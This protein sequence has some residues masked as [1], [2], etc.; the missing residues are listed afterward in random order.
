MTTTSKLSP[1]RQA[2]LKLIMA[3]YGPWYLL[4]L[5]SDEWHLCWCHN[6]YD[7]Q[8]M[9]S[10]LIDD[11]TGGSHCFSTR[12]EALKEVLK[13]LDS[14]IAD[15]G[16]GYIKA[17]QRALESL[18][19]ATNEQDP[20]AVQ[21][22]FAGTSDETDLIEAWL[23][24]DRSQAHEKRMAAK[25]RATF[26]AACTEQERRE[27]AFELVARVFADQVAGEVNDAIESAWVAGEPKSVRNAP[28]LKAGD[29]MPM[30][31][32]AISAG[33]AVFDIPG[34]AKHMPVKTPLSKRH[35]SQG[36]V[37]HWQHPTWLN[38]VVPAVARIIDRLEQEAKVVSPSGR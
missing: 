23:S 18:V 21:N 1:I 16:A 8:A 28:G 17:R 20:A 35:T 6:V 30:P 9:T 11:G 37:S 26:L 4:R 22:A 27:Q 24:S 36:Y 13:S 32:L 2:F 15:G 12:I 7:E 25:R 34:R 29:P 5:P 31:R 33:R 14:E 38:L 3:S 19:V 10:Y